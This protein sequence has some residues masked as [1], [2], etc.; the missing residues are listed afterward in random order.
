[1]LPSKDHGGNKLLKSILLLLYQPYKWLIFLPYVFISTL[2][3][4]TLAVIFSSTINQRMGSYIGGVIWARLICLLTPIIVKV[5]GQKNI[6][7]SQSY[8][9][10][11][12]HLSQYDI[13]ILYGWLKMDIRWVMKKELRKIPGLGIGSEKVGHIFID[14]SNP[15]KALESI[16]KARKKLQKGTSVVIF[17]EGTRSRDGKT[18]NFKK[19]AFRMAIDFQLPILPITISGTNTILPPGSFKLRPGKAKII[20][21][22]PLEVSQD[23][24][25]REV[26][27]IMDKSYGIIKNAPSD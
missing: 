8:V 17:P 26:K 6:E 16:K 11:A 5:S 22:P 25:A 10:I 3:F 2:I 1:M 7:P 9:I 14:R 24:S 27:K 15:G 20:I 18:A 12:N 4:G 13:L 23:S 19:G 21:H